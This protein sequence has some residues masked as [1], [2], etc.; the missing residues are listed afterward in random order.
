MDNKSF[1]DIQKNAENYLN[2]AKDLHKKSKSIFGKDY[3]NN[4]YLPKD[5]NFNENLCEDFFHSRKFNDDKTPLLLNNTLFE[6]FRLMEKVPVNSFYQFVSRDNKVTGQY[7][8]NVNNKNNITLFAF[9]LIQNTNDKN[10]FT[11]KLDMLFQGR[12]W[13]SLCRLDSKT[14][15]ECEGHI[16]YYT[17]DKIYNDKENTEVIYGPHFHYNCFNKQVLSLSKVDYYPAYKLTN[18]MLNYDGTNLFESC[19]NYFAKQTGLDKYINIKT[20]TENKSTKQN[21]FEK[22]IFLYSNQ[23]EKTNIL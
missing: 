15:D 18:E 6:K 11:I 23:D 4:Y 21:L 17:D 7:L 13:I 19:L 16:N 14:K 3:Y 20:F 10:D 9:T 1:Y 12:K 2:T 8:A 5:F 22:P